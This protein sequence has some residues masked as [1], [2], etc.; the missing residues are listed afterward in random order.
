MKDGIYLKYDKI[1]GPDW[2]FRIQITAGEVIAAQ[3]GRFLTRNASTGYG[4]IADTT[5]AIIGWAEAAAD[6]ST[7][8]GLVVKCLHSL[9]AIF[10]IPLIYDNS[11]YTVNY[12][13][14][15]LFECCD[16]KVSGGIQYANPTAA[17][18][19]TLIIVGGK[20]ASGT[21]IVSNDGYLDVMINPMAR[22]NLGVGA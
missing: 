15:I 9:D 12:S 11:T 16:L 18:N 1:N 10:R 2:G 21:S 22:L 6:S 8:A 17:T 19:K 3:S 13:D 4:E 20:A 14:A 5:D 7:D